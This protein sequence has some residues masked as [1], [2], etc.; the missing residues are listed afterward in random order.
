MS[1]SVRAPKRSAITKRRS[2]AVNAAREYF[3]HDMENI[4]AEDECAGND[5]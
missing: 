3:T 4:D 2:T 5:R 1:G